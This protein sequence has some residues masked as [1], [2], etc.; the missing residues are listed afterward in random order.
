MNYL[1][2]YRLAWLAPLIVIYLTAML[3]LAAQT[4]VVKVTL[5]LIL[6]LSVITLVSLLNAINEI[7]ESRKNYK[8]V[9][10]AGYLDIGKIFLVLVGMILSVTLFTDKSP[11]A[12]LTGLGAMAA[13]L[14]LIFQNT[15]L[16]LVS[17]IQISANDLL[18]EGDWIEVPSYDADGDMVNINLHTIKI[19]NFDMTLYIKYDV[20]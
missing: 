10:I 17:S 18:K 4:I 11:L 15:I 16:S 7:Y 8:G 12:L 3:F 9:S 2:P 5:F 1:R 20:C 6:W 13:M 19:R 14:L